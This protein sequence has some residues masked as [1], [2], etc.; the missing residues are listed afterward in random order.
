MPAHKNVNTV[1]TPSNIEA[2]NATASSDSMLL[3]FFTALPPAGEL[4]KDVQNSAD[5]RNPEERRT[6]AKNQC[7]DGG[8]KGTN[9]V[10]ACMNH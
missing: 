8:K 3:C 5:R 4:N 9:S 6:S 1:P 10:L 2:N 7:N